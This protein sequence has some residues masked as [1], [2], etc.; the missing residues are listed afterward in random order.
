MNTNPSSATPGQKPNLAGSPN[1]AESHS[2]AASVSS[3]S[4]PDYNDMHGTAQQFS[5]H[6]YEA[7]LDSVQ[8]AQSGS[9]QKGSRLRTELSN[10][11]KDLDSLM[12]RASSLNENDLRNA[13]DR[14]MTRFS[15]MQASAKGFASDANRRAGEAKQ[16][17]NQGVET[18]TEYVKERPLQSV[19]IAAGIGF[20]L[21]ALF[22]RDR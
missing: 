19:A 10:L 14:I 11:K 8:A 20:V 18:G 15:A 2:T 4:T 22:R 13:R 6:Q 21:G 17:L 16:Q 3:P 5:A 1:N 7:D 9:G 12:S